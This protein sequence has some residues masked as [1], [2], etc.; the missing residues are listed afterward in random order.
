M[1][2]HID[3]MFKVPNNEEG[4]YF[5]SLLKKY[6]T[7]DVSVRIKGRTPDKEKARRKGCRWWKSLGVADG[8]ISQEYAK[9]LGVYMT[10]KTGE[11]GRSLNH[12]IGASTTVWQHEHQRTNWKMQDKLRDIQRIVNS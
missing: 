10:V 8:S 1:E 2:K 3:Q 9:E 4:R 11:N 5:I 12:T 7:D 6:S